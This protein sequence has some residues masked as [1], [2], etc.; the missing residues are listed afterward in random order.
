MEDWSDEL[1]VW[2]SETGEY[3]IYIK[4]NIIKIVYC[5]YLYKSVEYEDWKGIKC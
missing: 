2:Y 1:G 5:V 4:Y 3:K